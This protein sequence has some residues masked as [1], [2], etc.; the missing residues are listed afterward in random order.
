LDEMIE[1][2]LRESYT[3]LDKNLQSSRRY[4]NLHDTM[5]EFEK[6]ILENAIALCHTTYDLAGYL[7]IS[8]TSA[9]RKLKK[10]GL[11]LH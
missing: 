2:I 11:S 3:P 9:F 10:H 1:M 8:Q 5:M 6:K 7:G 4:K